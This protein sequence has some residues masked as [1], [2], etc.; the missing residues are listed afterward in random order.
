MV[1]PSDSKEM[2]RKYGH[3]RIVVR[4]STLLE[5][6]ILFQEYLER[7]FKATPKAQ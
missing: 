4:A 7:I 5:N 6:E 1:T 3:S 2:K